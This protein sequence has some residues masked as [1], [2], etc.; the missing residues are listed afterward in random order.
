MFKQNDD[1]IFMIKDATRRVAEVR[2]KK[3][4]TQ[5]ELAEKLD[6]ELRT[7]QNYET[8]YVP[9][10]ALCKLA[11]ALECSL[12]DLLQAPETPKNTRGR[13]RKKIQ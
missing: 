10:R 13:P 9:F 3:N 12:E 5:A 1:I 6:V 2:I 7:V 11:I 8:K 4:L